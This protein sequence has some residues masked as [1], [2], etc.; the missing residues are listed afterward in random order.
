MTHEKISKQH[1][2]RKRKKRSNYYL[3][4][5]KLCVFYFLPFFLR[6]QL[7]NKFTFGKEFSIRLSKIYIWIIIFTIS[8][9]TLLNILFYRKVLSCLNFCN[10]DHKKTKIEKVPN[11]LKVMT[12]AF[13]Y[14]FLFYSIFILVWCRCLYNSCNNLLLFLEFMSKFV[15]R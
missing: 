8:K 3:T 12:A 9:K 15:W 1:L 11:K 5:L 4:S 6:W 10:T 7:W 14:L 13:M 2:K